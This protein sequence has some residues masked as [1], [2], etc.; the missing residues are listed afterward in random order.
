[1]A[2]AV[3]KAPAMIRAIRGVYVWT[4]LAIVACS[5][6]NHARP[7]GRH[8]APEDDSPA[9]ATPDLSAPPT[10]TPT[11]VPLEV[12]ADGRESALVFELDE[13]SRNE[14]AFSL[15]L[16]VHNIVV[17]S[18]A[19]LQVNGGS[20]LELSVTPFLHRSGGEVARGAVPIDASILRI[21]RN[22]VV[23]QYPHYAKL[24][25][26]EISGFRVLSAQ[27]RAG[28]RIVPPS[29]ATTP[30]PSEARV[31]AASIERGRALFAQRTKAS[32]ACADC[33]APSGADL[34]YYGFSDR[35]IIG[36]SAL[37]ELSADDAVAIASYVRA[38][39]VPVRGRPFDPPLQSG[40]QNTEAAGAGYASV[41]DSDDAFRARLF[42]SGVP[43]TLGWDAVASV[44]T[45]RLATSVAFPSWHRWLPRRL[46]ADWF[47][48][49]GGI[50][51]TTEVALRKDPSVANANAF[52]S[53]AMNVGKEVLIEKGDH[54]GRINLL[55]FA[56]VRLWDWSRSLG[57]DAGHHGVPDGSPA[58]AY[59][60]GFA[61][62]EAALA[63][64]PISGAMRQVASWWW[65][66]LATYPGRGLSNGRRPL[67]FDEVL[68]VADAAAVGPS[69]LLFLH[70]YGSWEEDRSMPSSFGTELG[71]V[72][73]LAVPMRR[74]SAQDRVGV[75][76]RFLAKESEYTATG[77]LTVGHH[78]ALAKA[79]QTGCT[80][81]GPELVASIRAKAP[82]AVSADFGDCIK[83]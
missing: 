30:G 23:F 41:L 67:N 32:P 10:C 36:R 71:P 62:F 29:S 34:K 11:S 14:K 80:G 63:D 78:A 25:G 1:M 66:Q 61:I 33:H 50:V 47:T 51:A 13:A 31:D 58:Y 12:F 83:P 70:L 48:R 45:F 6:S 15:E 44:D 56:A 73:L 22:C 5:E 24:D 17:P 38:L 8:L 16:T 21:G 74:L 27:L 35:S 65:A 76:L 28:D 53:A 19:S 40:S 77:T 60:V 2:H 46:E 20:A 7:D 42:P 18:S 81:L 54:D 75:L 39:Q 52:M 72:R 26:A 9:P 68:K 59:E 79:W 49:Q 57:F 43:A 4:L 69:E 55:R 64:A 82:A 3:M 37:H